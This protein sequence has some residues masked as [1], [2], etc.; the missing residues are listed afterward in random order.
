MAINFDEYQKAS[1]E[2]LE[3][4]QA[5]AQE[6]SK[7]LQAIAAENTDFAKKSLEHGSAFVEKLLSVT[8]VEDAFALQQDFAKSSYEGFVA[9]ATKLGE[10]YANI[11]KEAFKPVEG[12]ISKVKTSVN[13]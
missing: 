8:K 7:Q 5:S 3:A 11:A 2:Q 9:Q 13:A 10:L 6:V 12:A 4:I 1:K